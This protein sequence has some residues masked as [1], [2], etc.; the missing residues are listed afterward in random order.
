[1]FR[2][3]YLLYIFSTISEFPPAPQYLHFIII[4]PPRI[5]KDSVAL[6]ALFSDPQ[7]ASLPYPSNVSIALF[8]SQRMIS[9]YSDSR[10]FPSRRGAT[11]SDPND[12]PARPTPRCAIAP[13]P[14]ILPICPSGYCGK[15]CNLATL[16][17]PAR[18]TLPNVSVRAT[19]WRALRTL[20]M[21]L[22]Q[23]RFALWLRR[24]R[25]LQ[26]RRR[27]PWRQSREFCNC[28]H[29]ARL[30]QYSPIHARSGR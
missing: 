9:D 13:D 24:F 28:V 17:G 5:P 26:R 29:W 10:P 15:C 8:P 20:P 30:R 6:A 18:R 27:R 22:P 16:Q 21:P 4:D 12:F 2:P 3:K 25:I 19:P 7:F 11:P 23:H 1:M 14:S